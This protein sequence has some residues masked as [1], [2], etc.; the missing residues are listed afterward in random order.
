MVDLGHLGGGVSQALA[1]NNNGGVVGTS[2]LNNGAHHAFRWT[3]AEGM[4]DL[5]TV[6][7]PRGSWV[8]LVAWDINDRGQI[9]GEGLHN[10]AQHAFRLNP[11]E[12]VT[13]SARKSGK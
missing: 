6:L 13:S 3:Q 10:G 7:P 2:T 9:T 12:L 11:R 5:N 4:I 1:I 8:L